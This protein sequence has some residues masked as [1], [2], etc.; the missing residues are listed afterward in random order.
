M[1]D[2]AAAAAIGAAPNPMDSVLEWIGFTTPGDRNRIMEEALGSL[3]D[4]ERI[5]ADDIKEIARDFSK[6]RGNQRLDFGYNRMQRLKNVVHWA[7]DFYRCSEVPTIEGLDQDSFLAALA[8][9]ADRESVRAT[10][11]EM[12]DT[13]SSQAAPGKLVGEKKWVEWQSAMENYLSTIIGSFGVPLAYVIRENDDPQPDGHTDFVQRCVACAPLQGV[14]YESDKRQVHQL[15]L[16]F[17]QGETA[18]EWIKGIKTRC[19]GRR[20]MRLLRDHFAGE[21]NTTRRISEAER[22]RDTLHYKSERSMS[23]EVFLDKVQKMLTIFREED[24]EW[25][26]DAKIRW[27]FSKVQNPQLTSIV[28][29]L[30]VRKISDPNLTYATVCNQLAAEVSELPE[31]VAMRSRNISAV[32]GDNGNGNGPRNGIYGADGA[33]HV[34]Y[35]KNWGSLT[36]EERSKVIA[37]RTKQGV[38]GSPKKSRHFKAK[39]KVA[40]IT[41]ELKKMKRKVS[42]LTKLQKASESPDGDD[43]SDE[44]VADDAGNQFGGRSAKAKKGRKSE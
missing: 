43:E 33:I 8:V 30:K 11:I 12:S 10:A 28:S 4:L 37:E 22:L 6:R 13:L 42:A 29:A 35:Y 21:G 36:K 40:K 3:A 15:I 41:S 16:G 5:K 2:D 20:D 18:E 39:K 17:V 27:I 7:Q 25:S 19:D 44:S 31:T 9:A 32:S 14:H 24:E 34:G 1:A 23:F 38:T 26:E